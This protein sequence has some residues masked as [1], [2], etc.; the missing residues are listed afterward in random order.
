M[1]ILILSGIPCSGKTTYAKK[2]QKLSGYQIIS[3]DDIRMRL[4]GKRYKQNSNGEFIVTR[5]FEKLLFNAALAD[6]D[7][8]LDNTFC[9]ERYINEVLER[10]GVFKNAQICIKFFDISLG[11]AY[12]RNVLRYLKTGKY[13]PR[14]VIKNMYKN[15]KKI[16]KEQY[17]DLVYI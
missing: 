4:F 16:K 6:K 2:L 9:K 11:V 8:I 15:Y 10:C 17:A 5:E 1:K 14:S 3:R 7:T 13:I 12:I